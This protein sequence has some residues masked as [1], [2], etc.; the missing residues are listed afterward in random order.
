MKLPM[1]RP[2]TP[3]E[4]S[5]NQRELTCSSEIEKLEMQEASLEYELEQ[6]IDETRRMIIVQ[7]LRVIYR[8]LLTQYRE[9]A[10]VRGSQITS[11]QRTLRSSE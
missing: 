6:D 3:E 2:L 5:L 9:L 7:T 11:L 8:A 4:I 1:T 10:R